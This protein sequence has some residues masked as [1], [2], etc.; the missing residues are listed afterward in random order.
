LSYSANPRIRH[1]KPKGE[2]VL[3]EQS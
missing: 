3:T 2:Q 1:L